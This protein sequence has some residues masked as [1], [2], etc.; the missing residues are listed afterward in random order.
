MEEKRCQFFW[1]ELCLFIEE[2]TQIAVIWDGDYQEWERVGR[3]KS[4]IVV[5]LY[6]GLTVTA[7]RILVINLDDDEKPLALTTPPKLR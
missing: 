4:G 7:R 5:D 1:A 3:D 6:F 2:I